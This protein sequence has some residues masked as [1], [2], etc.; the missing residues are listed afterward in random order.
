MSDL[1]VDLKM[2]RNAWLSDQAAILYGNGDRARYADRSD[3]DLARAWQLGEC[4]DALSDVMR[5]HESTAAGRI[6]ENI[7]RRQ[8]PAL[9]PNGEL[10]AAI[11]RSIFGPWL[12]PRYALARQGQG[13]VWWKEVEARWFGYFAEDCPICGYRIYGFEWDGQGTPAIGRPGIRQGICKLCIAE[14]RAVPHDSSGPY[15]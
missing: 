8:E 6:I 3:Q 2:L 11:N 14:G 15:Q 9:P 13:R 10:E 4:A 12:A 1:E 7:A 5:T